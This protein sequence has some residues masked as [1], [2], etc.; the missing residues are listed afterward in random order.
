MHAYGQRA[1]RPLQAV[2][3]LQL[4]LKAFAYSS[5]SRGRGGP[6]RAGN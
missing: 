6:K 3:A 4:H 1:V 2:P 5:R